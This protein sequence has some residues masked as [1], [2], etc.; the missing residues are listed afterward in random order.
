MNEKAGDG[1]QLGMK[2]VSE[3]VFVCSNCGNEFSKWSGQCSACGE[4]NSLKEMKGQKSK[5]LNSKRNSSIKA[6]V[7]KLSKLRW[8]EIVMQVCF[9]RK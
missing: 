1:L 5:N 4:W 9:C 2:K 7:K 8:S 6:E 3:T